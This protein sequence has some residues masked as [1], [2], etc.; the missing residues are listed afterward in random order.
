MGPGANTIHKESTPGDFKLSD[1][2]WCIVYFPAKIGLKIDTFLT[3]M[4]T[5][6]IADSYS[7]AMDY[8]H[9]KE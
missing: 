8:C 7:W 4:G 3:L 2:I 6:L 1:P 5:N 9:I